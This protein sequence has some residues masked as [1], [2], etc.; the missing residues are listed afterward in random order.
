M[1]SAL[2][3]LFLIT[4]AAQW[5]IWLAEATEWFIRQAIRRGA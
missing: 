1:A 4:G 5:L 3:I 2:F